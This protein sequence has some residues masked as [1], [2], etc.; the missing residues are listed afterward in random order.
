[1]IESTV[2]WINVM[3]PGKKDP[4]TTGNKGFLINKMIPEC[5][6]NRQVLKTKE[7]T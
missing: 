3:S 6:T 5:H 7:M 4:A 2:T 1:M